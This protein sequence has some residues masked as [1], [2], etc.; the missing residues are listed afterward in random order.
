M[1]P[2][3]LIV[4]DHKTVRKA[5]RDWLRTMFPT[6]HVIEATNADEAIAICQSESPHLVLMDITMPGITGIEATR[7]I[8]DISPTTP[9]V[10][11]TIHDDK[12]YRAESEAAGANAYIT[13]AA[14]HS[15]LI[16]TLSALLDEIRINWELIPQPE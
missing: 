14:L 3:I 5:L 13:K 16:P 6:C 15:E 8:K 9:V 10:M 11:L 12:S 4:D 7:Q 1:S 2:T